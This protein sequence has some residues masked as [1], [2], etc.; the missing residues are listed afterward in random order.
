MRILHTMYWAYTR[1]IY[2]HVLHCPF[3]RAAT[4]LPV[5]ECWT[6]DDPGW[7]FFVYPAGEQYPLERAHDDQRPDM[8]VSFCSNLCICL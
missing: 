8:V 6:T 5:F 7:N 1:R 2:L 3:L 4:V